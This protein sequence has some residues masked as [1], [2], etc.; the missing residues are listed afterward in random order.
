MTQVYQL[1]F[2]SDSPF[3]DKVLLE[4][5]GLHVLLLAVH[6]FCCADQ[7]EVGIPSLWDSEF[8]LGLVNL[9]I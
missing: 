3:F 9:R 6:L 5:G 7:V 8:R 2:H 1:D 4:H